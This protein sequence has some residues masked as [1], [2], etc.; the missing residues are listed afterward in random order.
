MPTPAW[1]AMS[2]SERDTCGREGLTARGEQF[3]AV[4]PRVRAELGSSVALPSSISCKTEVASASLHRSG[5]SLR[6]TSVAR[7]NEYGRHGMTRI[8]TRFG[9][10]STAAEVA[11]GIDLAGS[12]IIVTGGGVRDRRRDGAGAGRHGRRGDARGPRIEAGEAGADIAGRPATR[13][14]GRAARPGGPG[15]IAA[16]AAAWTG[17]STSSSTTPG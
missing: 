2:S 13:R 11:A 16:F 7:T 9:R 10:G 5:G 12:R 17:R 15:P 8:T 14:C 1:R 6:I 4:A 3:L